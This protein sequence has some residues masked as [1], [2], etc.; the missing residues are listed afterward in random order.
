MTE[1]VKIIDEN[2]P[3]VNTIIREW[4]WCCNG[5]GGVDVVIFVGVWW[6]IDCGCNGGCIVSVLW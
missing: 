4:W 1:V 5:G 3:E 2:I 6:F